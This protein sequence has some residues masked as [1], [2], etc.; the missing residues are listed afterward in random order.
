MYFFAWWSSAE[1]CCISV[2]KNG[3]KIVWLYIILIPHKRIL[4]EIIWVNWSFGNFICSKNVISFI[5]FKNPVKVKL[6]CVLVLRLLWVLVFKDSLQM[7]IQGL[8]NINICW[9]LSDKNKV[10]YHHSIKIANCKLGDLSWFQSSF[11]LALHYLERCA[12]N[13][14]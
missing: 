13:T 5:V 10:V 3:S 1:Q 8:P 4:L 14:T 9:S 6:L 11:C 2:R 12:F 7:L